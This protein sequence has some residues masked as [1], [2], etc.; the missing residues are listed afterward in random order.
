MCNGCI[1]VVV[2][3]F[4]SCL[5]SLLLAHCCFPEASF[6]V[7]GTIVVV[8]DIIVVVAYFLVCYLLCL[9]AC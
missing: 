5:V 8:V 2:G 7:G 3:L 6:S 9:F 4:G 1:L